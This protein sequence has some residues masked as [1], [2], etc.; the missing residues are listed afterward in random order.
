[1]VT[2][3]ANYTSC[4]TELFTRLIED[5]DFYLFFNKT[6]SNKLCL[7]FVYLSADGYAKANVLTVKAM[8][9]VALAMLS[10]IAFEMRSSKLI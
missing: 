4:D 5:S 6:T 9:L 2:F 8:P 1:M 10:D 7:D 3:P